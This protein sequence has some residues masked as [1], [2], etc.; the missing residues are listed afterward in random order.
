M[1]KK[2]IFL[3]LIVLAGL[4]AAIFL[5]KY[6][7]ATKTSVLPGNNTESPD[8]SAVS[9]ENSAESPAEN[10]IPAINQET[11]EE[12][13]NVYEHA[14]ADFRLTYPGNWTGQ[15]N[16][17]P[18]IA[19][20]FQSPKENE[21]DT[22]GENVIVRYVSATS[23][24][25]LRQFSDVMLAQEEKRFPQGAFSIISRDSATLSGLPA[26]RIVYRA[27]KAVNKKADGK[28]LS[29]I[30]IKGQQGYVVTYSAAESSFDKFLNDANMIFNS[31]EVIN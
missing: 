31:F 9:Q 13:G 30:M 26:E 5:F 22:F 29:M 6:F 1:D 19:A 14:T 7:S 3:V 12:T 8:A 18:E 21:S 23:T 2:I 28:A 24:M 16:V 11:P 17:T 4:A 20:F 15:G 25:T 10:N 27:I